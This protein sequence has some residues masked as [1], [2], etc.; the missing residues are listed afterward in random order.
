MTVKVLG[1]E[2][3][4]KITAASGIQ[5]EGYVY[6]QPLD[7]KELNTGIVLSCLD[8]STPI[9]KSGTPLVLV[10][11]LFWLRGRWERLPEH[12]ADRILAQRFLVE[13]P[14]A[15]REMVA[16]RLH[17]VDA[18]LPASAI[19]PEV[20]ENGELVVFYPGGM[21][22]PYLGIEYQ[23][24]YMRWGIDV[25]AESMKEASLY[26]A[27]FVVVTPPQLLG[28][29]AVM[30]VADAGGRIES[31][32]TDLGHLLRDSRCLVLAPGIEIMLEACA[33]GKV[34]HYVPAFNGSHI[35]QLMAYRQAGIGKELCPSYAD[36]LRGLEA[37]T[38]NLSRLSMEVEQ[39][40]FNALLQP[41]YRQEAVA[42]LVSALALR[43]TIADRYPLG[44]Y[45]AAQVVDHAVEMLGR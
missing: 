1:D 21:R 10:D 5:A 37:E 45:G 44:K 29:M 28:S 4:Q 35:P 30:A 25:V 27:N 43:E 36:T 41:E 39:Q 32:V 26:A 14:Q 7:L 8:V 31:S 15:V 23:E 20:N 34:P 40:N 16:D 33:N 11:S 24:R 3:A 22:S 17:T 12:N 38:D 9:T 19:G 18:I 6:R 2:S 42:N 13:A